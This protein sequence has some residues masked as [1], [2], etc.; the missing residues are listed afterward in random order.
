NA[1]VDSRAD[2]A[3]ANN[4]TD[5]TPRPAIPVLDRPEKNAPV[6][7]RTHCQSSRFTS[8]KVSRLLHEAGFQFNSHAVHLAGDLV[9]AVAKADGFRLRTAF[10]HLVAATQ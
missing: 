9:V 6:A 7:R 10:E 3:L 5:R 2:N 4:A 1:P 8:G